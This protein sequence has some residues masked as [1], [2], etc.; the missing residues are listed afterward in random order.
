MIISNLDEVE[1]KEAKAEEDFK[2]L[3]N[4]VRAVPWYLQERTKVNLTK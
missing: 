1:I 3:Q 2:V 4:K